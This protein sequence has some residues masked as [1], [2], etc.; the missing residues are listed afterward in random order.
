MEPQIRQ[1]KLI[2][3]RLVSKV[4]D[5]NHGQLPDLPRQRA[6]WITKHHS[7]LLQGSVCSA[8]AA[9]KSLQSC[10]T[11]CDPIDGSPPGSAIPGIL[12]AGTLHRGTK[13][14]LGCRRLIVS[15]LWAFAHNK[16]SELLNTKKMWKKECDWV[17]WK[18]KNRQ[19]CSSP[20]SAR[21]NPLQVLAGSTLRS[22]QK[23]WLW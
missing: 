19:H 6:G 15:N 18:Q 11:L 16:I 7:C 14:S 21:I 1:S 20:S 10:P 23:K 4:A 17:R 8:A 9:A 2:W 22:R 3:V 12:P 5:F 13:A